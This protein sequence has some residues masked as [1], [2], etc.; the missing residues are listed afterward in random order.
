MQF[1]IFKL[2]K[3]KKILKVCPEVKFVFFESQVQASYA[4]LFFHFLQYGIK[5][6]SKKQ[7]GPTN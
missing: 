7:T 2:L 1:A 5:C 3:I 4:G 6:V